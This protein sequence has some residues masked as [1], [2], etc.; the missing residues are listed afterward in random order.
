MF[1]IVLNQLLKNLSNFSILL[2]SS[3]VFVSDHMLTN[4]HLTFLSF[5][6]CSTPIVLYQMQLTA[7]QVGLRDIFEHG[8]AAGL[9]CTS[10]LFQDSSNPGPAEALSW[11][12]QRDTWPNH[13]NPSSCRLPDAHCRERIQAK[14]GGIHRELLHYH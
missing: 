3:Q 2:S 5:P 8:E 9:L 14:G 12:V 4:T 10:A 11:A 13:R 6:S 7:S 1:S